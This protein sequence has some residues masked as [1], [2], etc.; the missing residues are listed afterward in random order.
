MYYWLCSL[1]IALAINE[2]WREALEQQHA[3]HSR[4]LAVHKLFIASA[5][6]RA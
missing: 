2:T 6:E 4:H 5:A 3:W 1:P